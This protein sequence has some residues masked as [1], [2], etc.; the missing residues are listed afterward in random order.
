MTSEGWAKIPPCAA[1]VLGTPSPSTWARPVGR[2]IRQDFSG[3]RV[4][5]ALRTRA[6][7][8][9]GRLCLASGS[10]LWAGQAAFL[11]LAIARAPWL[12]VPEGALG[13]RPALLVA[14]QEECS[15]VGG[16]AEVHRCPSQLGCRGVG[17]ATL[18]G[19]GVRGVGR[20]AGWERGRPAPP[21]I[22]A[23]FP[24][25]T[26]RLAPRTPLAP[27]CWP[28]AACGREVWGGSGLRDHPRGA[29]YSGYGIGGAPATWWTQGVLAEGPH[30]GWCGEALPS[31]SPPPRLPG[32]R[33][34]G[35][36][37][38]STAGPSGLRGDRGRG[39]AAPILSA[40]SRGCI[41]ESRLSSLPR[42]RPQ[43]TGGL[44]DLQRRPAASYP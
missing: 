12:Q 5:A 27:G 24:R 21:G 28:G 10:G 18:W 11:Q 4:L 2:H 36:G 22:R 15:G 13:S 20:R 3:W 7:G 43:V 31:F 37:P 34:T 44:A 17:C 23:P 9:C 35:A 39:G 41:A 30:V 40:D 29:P 38:G 19:S 8:R 1:P 25:S 32:E 26:H 6:A 14:P 42:K 16:V 33:Q